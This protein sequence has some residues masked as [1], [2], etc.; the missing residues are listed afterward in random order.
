MNTLFSDM[1]RLLGALLGGAKDI[2]LIGFEEYGRL[3]KRSVAP[4]LIAFAVGVS[5][6]VLSEFL[7]FSFLNAITVVSFGIGLFIIFLVATPIF[8]AGALVASI[9]WAPIRNI[10][11]LFSTL[12]VLVVTFALLAFRLPSGFVGL[13]LLGILAAF[14]FGL[15]ALGLRFSKKVLGVQL[16]SLAAFSTL[17]LAAPQVVEG[18]IDAAR[19]TLI[20]MGYSL[21]GAPPKLDMTEASLT[22]AGAQTQPLFDPDGDPRWWCRTEATAPSGFVCYG[23]PG[24]DSFNN[25]ELT[26]ISTGIVQ[27]ALARLRS[28][29]AAGDALREA[30]QRQ[31]DQKRASEDATRAAAAEADEARRLKTEQAEADAYRFRYVLNPQAKAALGVSATRDSLPSPDATRAVVN[32][33]GAPRGTP[34]L[35]DAAARDGVFDRLFASDPLEFQKLQLGR[36]SEQVLLLRITTKSRP[37]GDLAGFVVATATIDARRL[38]STS[39][40]LLATLESSAEASGRPESAIKDAQ[41]RAL[42]DVD[43]WIQ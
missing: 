38:D 9:E 42:E 28:H 15:S 22:G 36:V 43:E 20:G 23:R 6:A 26:P 13:Q 34:I 37:H 10:V 30:E 32:F 33:I 31:L 24:R 21:S 19:S 41:A 4:V 16:V 18:A 8:F 39:G 40:N 27:E 17:G 7:G 2:A 35:A 1:F 12:A 25:T 5:S 11:R 29:K 14:F 3:A